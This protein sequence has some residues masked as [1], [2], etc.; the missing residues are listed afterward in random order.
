MKVKHN[1]I[2]YPQVGD[3]KVTLGNYD[4]SLTPPTDYS[5]PSNTTKFG[6]NQILPELYTAATNKA[7]PVN[8]QRY[9]PQLYQPYNVSFQDRLN[10]SQA[11]FNALLKA[12]SYNPAAQSV[13]AGQKYE[14]DNQ[15]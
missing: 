6:I 3:Q 8:L 5:K 4:L 10:Q 12:N 9:D 15:V 14:A 7:E 2:Q 11:N 13:L 1:S